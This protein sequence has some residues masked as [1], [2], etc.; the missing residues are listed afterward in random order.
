MQPHR[1]RERFLGTRPLVTS[2]EPPVRSR[3]ASRRGAAAMPGSAPG[4]RVTDLTG[5][6]PASQL[7]SGAALHD[8][9]DAA[10]QRWRAAPHAAAALAWKYYSYWLSLPAVLGYATARRVPL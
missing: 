3:I 7:V 9:L 2:L 4:R 6:V 10:G 5:W 1:G 8:L